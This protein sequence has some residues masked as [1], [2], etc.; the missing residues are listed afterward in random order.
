[1]DENTREVVAVLSRQNVRIE[2]LP[3]GGCPDLKEV[4]SEDEAVP[5]KDVPIRVPLIV[6]TGYYCDID[7]RKFVTLLRNWQGDKQQNEYQNIA[8]R[9]AKSLRV[10]R[11]R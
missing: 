5:S 8:E 11:P 2:S 3:A 6:N 4:V 1:M 9:V 7:G 10:T